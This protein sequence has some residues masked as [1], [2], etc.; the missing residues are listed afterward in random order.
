MPIRYELFTFVDYGAGKGRVLMLAAEHPFRAVIGVEFSPELC[1]VANANLDKLS[2][3]AVRA[4]RVECVCADAA[5][6]LPPST[7]LVCYFYNPF[8]PTVLQA[9]IDR[10]AASM[11]EQPREIF[12]VYV[13]PEHRDVIESAGLWTVGETSDFHVVYRPRLLS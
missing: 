1:E 4:G 3:A 8:G 6:Y 9:V 11:R 10:L 12:L 5:A 2:S 13:H 7:P